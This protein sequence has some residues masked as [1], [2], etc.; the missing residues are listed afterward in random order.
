MM[1]EQAVLFGL[2]SL[3]QDVSAEAPTPESP[4]QPVSAEGTPTAEASG[5]QAAVDETTAADAAPAND[6]D[7][8][9]AEVAVAGEPP[10]AAPQD[11]PAPSPFG[12]M[13]LILGAGILIF[14]LLL[15]RPQKKE[16]QKR[17]NLFESIK[18]GDQVMTTAGIYGVVTEVNREGKRPTVVI[19]VDEK[20]N[21][22]MKI[23]LYGILERLEGGGDT[24]G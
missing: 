22:K 16:Q 21:A 2:L 13:F 15:I 8:G 9:Q 3:A 19:R 1:N 23:S 20:S 6:A 17:K 7:A 10:E 18:V 12:N 5:A 24:N 4:A 14:W 11:Q